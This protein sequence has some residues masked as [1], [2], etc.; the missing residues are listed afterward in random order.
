[1]SPKLSTGGGTRASR[2]SAVTA[3][4]IAVVV[5]AVLALVFIFQNTQSTTIRVLIPEVIMPLWLA[6]LSTAVI[7]ALCGALFLSRRR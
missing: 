5:L 1:M 3:G 6:L 7:G 4:R 2:G